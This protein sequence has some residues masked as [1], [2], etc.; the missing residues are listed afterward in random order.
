VAQVL[1]EYLEVMVELTLVE[2]MELLIL[3]AAA[4]VLAVLG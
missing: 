1:R 4:E 3:A 2:T